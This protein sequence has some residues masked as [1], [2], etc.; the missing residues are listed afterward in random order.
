MRILSQVKILENIKQ[1]ESNRGEKEKQSKPLTRGD[2]FIFSS[3]SFSTKKIL[4]K[5]TA[6]EVVHGVY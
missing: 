6:A 2:D 3:I 1:H 4:Q 5:K